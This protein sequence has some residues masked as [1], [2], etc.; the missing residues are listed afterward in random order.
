MPEVAFLLSCISQGTYVLMSREGLYS[1]E[2]KTFEQHS[3]VYC[4]KIFSSHFCSECVAILY[5]ENV[6]L[7]SPISCNDMISLG[8]VLTAAFTVYFETISGWDW[9]EAITLKNKAKSVKF[10]DYCK[11]ILQLLSVRSAVSK[12][13]QKVCILQ[14]PS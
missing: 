7:V 9:I 8:V 11:S 13:T 10:H 1:V 4:L 2:I 5:D 12:Q 14:T 6:S 3:T